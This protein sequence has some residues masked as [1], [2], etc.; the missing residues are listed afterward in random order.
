MLF[1]EENREGRFASDCRGRVEAI[2]G[3]TVTEG[4]LNR[5]A[6]VMLEPDVRVGDCENREASFSEADNPRLSAN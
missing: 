3:G 2:C 4:G 5:G 6:F 1:G